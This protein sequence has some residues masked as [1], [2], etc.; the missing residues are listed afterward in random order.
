[1]SA[2][3]SVPSIYDEAFWVSQEELLLLKR[4][5]RVAL[6][7]NYDPELK[8]EEIATLIRLCGAS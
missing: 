3:A 2:V 5:A 1:M 4:A 7:A 8:L 6:G